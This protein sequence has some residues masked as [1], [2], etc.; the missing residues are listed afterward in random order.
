[1]QPAAVPPSRLRFGNR[2]IG[3]PLCL[4]AKSSSQALCRFNQESA[5]MPKCRARHAQ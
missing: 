2:G 4:R 3:L 5:G 1:M